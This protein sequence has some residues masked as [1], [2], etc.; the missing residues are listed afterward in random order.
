MDPVD[1]PEGGI[2]DPDGG[3]NPPDAGP[4]CGNAVMAS[5]RPINHKPGG[6]K[7]EYLA[8]YQPGKDGKGEPARLVYTGRRQVQVSIPFKLAG[9]ELK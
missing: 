3:V 2:F 8:T 7:V 1:A 4:F 9:V 5:I 6:S